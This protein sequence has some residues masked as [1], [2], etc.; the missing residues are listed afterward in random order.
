MALSPSTPQRRGPSPR[1]RP[2]IEALS[3]IE[4]HVLSALAAHSA[5]GHERDDLSRAVT[6]A[7]ERLRALDD[8]LDALTEGLERAQRDAVQQM[9]KDMV[10]LRG[11]LQ[12]YTAVMAIAVIAAVLLL[13]ILILFKIG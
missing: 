13:S 10:E 7:K 5:A 2:L 12:R 11:D 9:A 4:V 6:S 8:E 1:V 3:Q